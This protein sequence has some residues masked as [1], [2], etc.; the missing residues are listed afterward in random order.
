MSFRG[1]VFDTLNGC[2]SFNG[3]LFLFGRLEQLERRRHMLLARV[4]LASQIQRFLHT[5]KIDDEIVSRY[6]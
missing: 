1:D 4:R 3:C 2:S 5:V 6:L